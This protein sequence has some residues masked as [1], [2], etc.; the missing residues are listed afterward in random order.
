MSTKSCYSL[1]ILRNAI[2][3]TYN[4]I[5]DLRK[6]ILSPKKRAQSVEEAIV[7]AE[8]EFYKAEST[9]TVMNGEPV[10]GDNP[11]KLKRLKSVLE[12]AKEE[13]VSVYESLEAKEAFLV[14]AINENESQQ[15]ISGSRRRRT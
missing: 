12:K 6:E 13:E 2:S 1:Q 15:S 7:I 14:R 5:N 4:R 11:A 8:A 9:L 3:K 10:V